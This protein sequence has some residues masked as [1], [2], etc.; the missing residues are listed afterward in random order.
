MVLP[1]GSVLLHADIDA[2]FAQVEAN[3][4]PHLKGKPLAIQQH[5]DIIAVTHDA[6]AAGVKKHMAPKEARALMQRIGGNV[7]HVHLEPGA[8]VSYGPYRDVSRTFVSLLRSFPAVSVIEK[9]S[10]DEA[11]LLCMPAPDSSTPL[12]MEQAVRVAQAIKKSAEEQLQLT[13]SIGCARNKLLAKLSSQAAKPN[14]LHAV[15]TSQEVHCL[16]STTPAKRLPRCGGKIAD[17]LTAAGVTTI[18]D[19]QG[20]SEA[21][22]R[23]D[24]GFQPDVA[25]SL[26]A[27]C[28]GQ[29]EEEV[30]EKGP[31]KTLSVQISLTPVPLA[32]HPA[33]GA[34]VSAAGGKAGMFEPLPLGQP[35][36]RMRLRSLLQAMGNDLLNRINMD[37]EDHHRWPK[38]MTVVMRA[39]SASKQSKS[40]T[41]S[42]AFPSPS[43]QNQAARQQDA[44]PPIPF[45]TGTKLEAAMLA[46]A[47]G[48]CQ[49]IAATLPAA[50]NLVELSYAATNF[51]SYAAAA[52]P[53]IASF[54]TKAP[55]STK[56]DPLHCTAAVLPCPESTIA[57]PMMGGLPQHEALVHSRDKGHSRDAQ[58]D[59]HAGQLG[60]DYKSVHQRSSKAAPAV[61]QESPAQAASFTGA[62]HRPRCHHIGAGHD[63]ESGPGQEH[64]PT[65]PMAANTAQL[66]PT[67]DSTQ[68]SMPTCSSQPDTNVSTAQQQ[69]AGTKRK[70]AES[71]STSTNES[72]LLASGLE[73]SFRAS[74]VMQGLSRAHIEPCSASSLS[75]PK[76]SASLQQVDSPTTPYIGVHRFAPTNGVDGPPPTASE[77]CLHKE[78]GDQSAHPSVEALS[79]EARLCARLNQ[80]AVEEQRKILRDIELR[81]LASL[82]GK[83]RGVLPSK[84]LSKTKPSSSSFIQQTLLSSKLFKS[85]SSS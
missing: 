20:W 37:S 60:P 45:T 38:T 34:Q 19:V 56:Q 58:I 21:Q 74:D 50:W 85:K 7:V 29:C 12:P 59:Q 15:E 72:A 69:L 31:P 41:R 24:L 49:A 53:S 36:F 14:G 43:L 71:T 11:Y 47:E 23:Q 51:G 10:I 61:G 83:H 54:F 13:V 17:V 67:L 48:L 39:Y 16:L 9:A 8:R 55:A 84:A 4:N 22:L 30:A 79:A 68:C 35:H 2:F 76:E 70:V 73:Q 57:H 80:A 26:W 65:V 75:L 27:W 78:Q 40:G 1:A 77:E 28:R 42:S 46:N 82:P 44:D 62:Q 5:Q 25:A 33:A 64:G 52:S 81:R 6:R 63:P 66:I 3:R 18:A 32:M